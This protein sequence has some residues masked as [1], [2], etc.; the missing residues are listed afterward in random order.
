[1]GVMLIKTGLMGVRLI[2]TRLMGVKLIN[3]WLRG[4][5][6]KDGVNGGKINDTDMKITP[7][8]PSVTVNVNN[9]V[10]IASVLYMHNLFI[11]NR[12]TIL[13]YN[14]LPRLLEFKLVT[15]APRLEL[16]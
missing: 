5:V 11:D 2:K 8:Y 10:E 9:F 16:S 7:L 14:N 13:I 4:E 6:N 3:T 12:L 15:S 1:M